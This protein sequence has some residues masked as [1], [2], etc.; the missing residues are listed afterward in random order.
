VALF[1]SAAIGIF[2][3]AYP[4]RQAALLDT[5]VALRSEL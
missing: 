1:V 3:G 2:F 4:A 5:I